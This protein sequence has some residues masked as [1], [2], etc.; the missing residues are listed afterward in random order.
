MREKQSEERRSEEDAGDHLADDGRLAD[1]ERE[2]TDEA[3]DGEDDD[4]L[5]KELNGQ[6]ERG[7]EGRV[8]S[9]NADGN[10][11]G[12]RRRADNAS[13]RASAVGWLLGEALEGSCFWVEG[14][15]ADGDWKCAASWGG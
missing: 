7:H 14:L 12:G 1:F 15:G 11:Q 4:E 2:F 8:Q 3:A 6:R 10:S 13:V 9:A 5:E